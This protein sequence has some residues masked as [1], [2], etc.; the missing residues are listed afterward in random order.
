MKLSF[1]TGKPCQSGLAGTGKPCLTSAT[2]AAT[3]PAAAAAA[4]GRACGLGSRLVARPCRRRGAAVRQA[5]GL[6]AQVREVCLLELALLVQHL[7]PKVVLTSNTGDI[8]KLYG[9]A[10]TAF[11]LRQPANLLAGC[12]SLAAGGRPW[13]HIIAQ[14][15]GCPPSSSSIVTC[16]PHKGRCRRWGTLSAAAASAESIYQTTCTS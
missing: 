3:V 6:G 5:K 2:A 10:M 4:A 1:P 7:R 9:E 11:L 16:S 12:H 15:C 14:H 13:L 8:L